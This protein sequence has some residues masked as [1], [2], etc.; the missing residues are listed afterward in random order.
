[1]QSIFIL[2]STLPH[3]LTKVFGGFLLYSCASLALYPDALYSTH[4]RLLFLCNKL[5][6]IYYLKTIPTYVLT[7]LLVRN[8][9]IATWISC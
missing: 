8:L 2:S 4:I 5:P 3:P 1:M 9:G 6:Q 7:V